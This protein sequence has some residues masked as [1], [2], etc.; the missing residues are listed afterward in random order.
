MRLASPSSLIKINQ[1]FKRTSLATKTW[2]KNKFG[3]SETLT[4]QPP[5]RTALHLFDFSDYLWEIVL[6]PCKNPR[7]S[8]LAENFLS[9]PQFF[10]RLWRQSAIF[11]RPNQYNP[12]K[13]PIFICNGSSVI[14]QPSLISAFFNASWNLSFSTFSDFTWFVIFHHT[15]SA[16]HRHLQAKRCLPHIFRLLLRD[17][18][19]FYFFNTQV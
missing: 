14:V 19:T 13:I 5:R 11:P 12:S 15:Q 8:R 3:V 7:Y 10:L 1:N 6:M 4:R 9:R 17:R 16:P 2:H 18:L